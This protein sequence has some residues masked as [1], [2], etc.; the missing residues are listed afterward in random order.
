MQAEAA[1]QR[2][3]TLR[4]LGE[5]GEDLHLDGAQQSFRGPEGQAGL[6]NVIG[7][8]CGRSHIRSSMLRISNRPEKEPASMKRER[9]DRGRGAGAVASDT[10]LHEDEPGGE[11]VNG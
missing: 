9:S 2:F 4:T 10:S 1:C 6:Q 8:G 3:E 7:G 11:L 5:F